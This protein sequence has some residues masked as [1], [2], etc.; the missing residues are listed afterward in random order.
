MSRSWEELVAEGRRL[1]QEETDLKWSLGDLALRVTKSYGDDSLGK[2][3][4][5]IGI[6]LS[7][8]Q[9][10]RRVASAWEKSTRV[11]NV[12]WSVHREFASR[13]DRVELIESRDNWT[14]REAVRAVG[15][16]QADDVSRTTAEEKR[17]QFRELARDPEV[18]GDPETVDE[19]V[20]DPS[21]LAAIDN[22]MERNESEPR[23]TPKKKDD[24]EGLTLH[25]FIWDL[26]KLHKTIDRIAAA[27]AAN[28]IAITPDLAE[29]AVQEIEWLRTA[30]DHIESGLKGGSLDEELSAIL[31]DGGTR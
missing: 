7:S 5:A 2:W 12:A 16:P 20:R 27:V 30:L 24:D 21:A 31:Q 25:D 6:G 23:P 18:I 11:E 17:Q 14:Y 10:Y 15:R 9:E 22:A 8:A 3:A 1:V 13:D 26:R 19:V 28:K 4:N 29:A